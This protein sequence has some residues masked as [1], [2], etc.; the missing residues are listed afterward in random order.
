MPQ[1]LTQIQQVKSVNPLSFIQVSIRLSWFLAAPVECPDV[2]D[3]VFHCSSV[4]DKD[5]TSGWILGPISHCQSPGSCHQSVQQGLKAPCSC[6]YW[7]VLHFL[8]H[9]MCCV[10]GWL[11]CPIHKGQLTRVTD[12]VRNNTMTCFTLALWSR[13]LAQKVRIILVQ[14]T[15]I[16]GIKTHLRPMTPG[17]IK[18]HVS[19]NVQAFATE[20]LNVGVHPVRTVEKLGNALDGSEKTQNL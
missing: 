1:I 2:L 19:L 5:M 10:R 3:M 17:E 18:N 12:A 4:S 8:Q 20:G 11:S 7:H 6:T 16:L 14:R 9:V 15:D 13:I